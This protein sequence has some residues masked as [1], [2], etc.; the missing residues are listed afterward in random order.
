MLLFSDLHLSPRTYDTCMKVLRR[1]HREAKQRQVPVGFLGDFFDKVH[2]QGT[3]PVNILNELMR[4]F[5]KEW[6]VPMIMIPGNHDYF[7][8]AETEHGL[9]PFSYASEHIIVL[10]NPVV[11][12]RQLWVPWRRS[13]ETIGKIL[14]EN[15][16]I[17]V[18]FGHFDIVGF[19][20]SKTQVS[21]EGVSV[22]DFPVGIPVY[23]GH[24]H[25]PQQHGTIRYLG[26]PYQLT[27]SEAEDKK[28]LIVLDALHTVSERIPI[29]IGSHQY[30]WTSNELLARAHE[31]RAD[32]RVSVID[33]GQS[34]IKVCVQQLQDKNVIISV[35]RTNKPVETRI[36]GTQNMTPVDLMEEYAKLHGID[37]QAPAW[38][39]FSERLALIGT[40]MSRARPDMRPL[41]MLLKGFGPFVGPLT[42]SLEGHG[43]TLVSGESEG[44]KALSNGAG[45]SLATAGAWLWC[46]TGM[47]DGRPALP[48][49]CGSIINEEVG[50]A[51]VV[52]SGTVNGLA[53]EIER[54]MAKKKHHLKLV[55]GGENKTRATLN[56]TQH[57]IASELFGLDAGGRELFTWLVRNCVWSQHVVTRWLDASDTAAKAEIHTLA[58]VKV[59]SE[60]HTWAKLNLKTTTTDFNQYTVQKK[61]HHSIYEH[62]ITQHARSL[63][64]ATEWSCTQTKKIDRHR[65]DVERARTAHERGIQTLGEEPEYISDEELNTAEDALVDAKVV[66]ANMRTHE[67]ELGRNLPRE[68]LEIDY[69]AKERWLRQQPEANVPYHETRKQHCEAAKRARQVQRD[70]A[71]REFEKFKSEGTCSA[72]NRAF[73]K[74]DLGEAADHLRGLQ[75]NVEEKKTACQAANND[76]TVAKQQY[77]QS[78]KQD[79]TNNQCRE[80]I[81]KG[82]SL[83][84]LKTNI[85]KAAGQLVTHQLGVSRLRKIIGKKKQQYALYSTTKELCDELKATLDSMERTLLRYHQEQCPYDIS[86]DDVRSKKH[87]LE[88]TKSEQDVAAIKV[89]RWSSILRWSGPRG[90]Q[91]YALEYTVKK[92]ARLTTEWLQ[93][94]FSTD[95]CVATI[96]LNVFFD[97]KERLQRFIEYKDHYGVL[98]GGQWRRAQLAAFM[99]WRETNNFPLLIMDEPCTS[100]DIQGIHA[101][102]GTLRDWC[103]KDERRT[104]FFISHEP[105]QHRDKSMYHNHTRILHKRGRSTMATDQAPAKRPKKRNQVG[106]T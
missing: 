35:K 2:S 15:S 69:D 12:N 68:W 11:I 32:D 64:M 63:R 1:V 70:A 52:A 81:D 67:L 7:D 3:L 30:K 83:R 44:D 92:L 24:Y 80:Y 102:Q 16:D 96:K 45:K 58:N 55:I 99:A 59:W 76:L 51:T 6:S 103:E 26:S 10:D 46:L 66:L 88:K 105:E 73:D 85:Q 53:W 41:K 48:F 57:V 43:L 89:G 104:C 13:P 42:M 60:I 75:E 65:D 93:R 36:S 20:M 8:A 18:I 84:K 74:D 40:T 25:T 95:T 54:S 23:S 17:D 62:A 86:D 98:S 14:R 21:A 106:Q 47:T 91:T 49:G 71:C 78:V 34:S 77:T 79:N 19:K 82:R 33:D 9:T 50:K 39:L 37:T 27:L 28:A 72:C 100:M 56:G 31:L 5:E 61:H 97:E 22:T 101:V 87:E 4:F 90:I 29:D 38:L 94:L